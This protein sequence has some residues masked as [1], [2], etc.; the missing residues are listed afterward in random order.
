MTVIVIANACIQDNIAG[1]F[2]LSNEIDEKTGEYKVLAVARVTNPGEWASFPED[3]ARELIAADAAR[4]PTEEEWQL[5]RL[6]GAPPLEGESR[7]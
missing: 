5:R 3:V 1:N 6:S 4:E 7:A 2:A